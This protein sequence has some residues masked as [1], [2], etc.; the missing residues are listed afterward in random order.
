[1]RDVHGVGIGLRAEH[2]QELLD[3]RDLAIDWLE[4]VPESY[5]RRGPRVDRMLDALAERY[6]LVCHGISLSIGG[7]DPL[8]DDYLELVRSFMARFDSPFWSDHLAFTRHG[9]VYSHELLPLPMS[10]AVAAHVRERARVAAERIGAPLLLEN[11]SHYAAMPGT[12]LAEHAFLAAATEGAFILLDVN[13]ILVNEKNFGFD[14]N[15]M[16]DALPIDRVRQIHVAG[17][18]VRGDLAIDTHRGPT[19]DSVWALYRRVVARAGRLIPTLIEWDLD[20]PPLA[21]LADEV[22]RA[23]QEA[24]TALA[25]RTKVS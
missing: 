17:H 7:V 24:A 23:R 5:L 22:Q 21:T 10:E 11:V 9:G 1:M 18:D 4:I 12:T 25:G 2:E 8:D 19:P 20:I 6:P 14:A 15:A 16:V 13:N 3:E